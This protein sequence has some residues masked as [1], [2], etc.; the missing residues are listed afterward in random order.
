MSLIEK[1]R[2]IRFDMHKRL[3]ITAILLAIALSVTLAGVLVLRMDVSEAQKLKA[4]LQEEF[5]RLNDPR[6][7]FGNN[8]FH[9]LVMFVPVIGPIWGSYVLFNTGT[10]V[11]VIGIADEVPPI[12]Y[13]F[14]LML[15]PVFWLEFGVYSVAMAQSVVW[16]LQFL[17]GRGRKEAVRTCIL[18]TI[19]AAILLLAAVVEWVMISVGAG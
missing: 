2:T 17:R 12:L 9:T 11:A 16:L 4:E 14:L 8:F 10:I 5:D 1:L 6:F 13:L 19:C 3:V 7:I 15:T 18:V